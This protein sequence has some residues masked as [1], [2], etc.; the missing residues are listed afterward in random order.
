MPDLK[1]CPI[2]LVVV[3][4]VVVVVVEPTALDLAVVLVQYQP[5][6]ASS[7]NHLV[8]AA[9]VPLAY[10]ATAVVVAGPSLV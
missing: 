7:L 3:A 2:G 10:C 1:G 8:Q 5:W 9:E 6:T 4:E